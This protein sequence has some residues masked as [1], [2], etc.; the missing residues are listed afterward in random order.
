[1]LDLLPG[2]PG[3]VCRFPRKDARIGTQEGD[4]RVFLFRIELGPDQH[5]LGGVVEAE[6]HRLRISG[7]VVG[8]RSLLLRNLLAL[9]VVLLY[10]RG[11]SMESCG[12]VDSFGDL[13]SLLLAGE[14]SGD[15]APER[16]DAVFRR[17][18]KHQIRVVRYGHESGQSWATEYGVV[19]VVEVGDQEVNG[20]LPE[21]LQGPE[22]DS[23]SHL[24]ER[25]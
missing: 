6:A 13:E 5:R 3:H 8:A 1:M 16:K 4:E 2:Y 24:P 9:L 14:C 11:E 20:L 15:V 23:K 25:H 12:E 21:I 10:L 7:L 18:F 17:H 22:L 19:G